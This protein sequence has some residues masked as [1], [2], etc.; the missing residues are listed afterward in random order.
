MKSPA[1]RA[2]STSRVKWTKWANRLLADKVL[3]DKQITGS[4]KSPLA[5]QVQVLALRLDLGSEYKSLLADETFM[6][7][8]THNTSDYAVVQKR[9][10]PV[11][12]A[13]SY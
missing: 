8:V 5:L 4:G 1:T 13:F 9:F 2:F 3:R 6:K 7:A 12:S 11:H 10:E